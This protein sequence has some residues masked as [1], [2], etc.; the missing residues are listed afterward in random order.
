MN[1][2]IIGSGG[3]EHAIA[4]KLKEG[5]SGRLFC[6]PGNGG[7]SEIASCEYLDLNDFRAVYGFSDKNDIGL[8]V[9]G[10]EAPLAAGLSDYLRLKGIKV[11]G[12]S[13]KGARLEASKVYAKEF[14]ERYGIPTAEYGSFDDFREAEKFIKETD[15]QGIVVKADGLAAGKGVFVCRTKKDAAD[16]AYEM[17]V[18]KRFGGS[19]EKI[20]IEKME[21]GEELSLMAFCDGETILPLIPAQDYKRVN[22]GGLG[23]NTGGMGSAA[24][25]NILT[26]SEISSAEK[27]IFGNFL[28]GINKENMDYRGIIYAGIMRTAKGLKTLEFNV[29]FGDPETQ[30][31]LPL[32][33]TDLL[34]VMTAA[35]ERSLKKIKLSWD[36]KYCVSVVLSSGGYPV[37]YS[38]GYEIQGLDKVSGV[39]VFHSGTVKKDGRFLTSGGRVLCVSSLGETIED[40]RKTVYGE[41]SK[42]SWPAMHYRKDIGSS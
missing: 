16:A 29:R 15:W 39:Q 41:I 26:P 27:D 30:A 3:R 35:A 12:P 5:F 14:M 36:K 6:V 40:A 21:E 10:P 18:N 32:L 33:E 25:V 2:L 31:V 17:L 28:S 37:K 22:D 23:P 38:T 13:K 24:P 7:I 11:F 20:I 8:A 4:W 1:I 42:I 9:I 34:E 19:G